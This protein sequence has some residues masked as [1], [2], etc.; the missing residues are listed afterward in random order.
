[1]SMTTIREILGSR[2]LFSVGPQTTLRDA[3]IEMSKNVVG[4]VAVTD[5]GTLAGILTE[6]DIVFRC[7]GCGFSVDKMTAAEVMT[8]DPVSVEIDDAIS[9]ALAMK[10]GGP[11]RHLPV[12]EQGKVVGVLSYRDIPAEY[13]MLFE[14]FRE[15]K[16]ARADGVK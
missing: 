2:P 9:D 6:R 16:S 10:I 4:A 14:R 1:M 5:D 13:A 7:I 12:V 15:M 3:A 8:R 11:F